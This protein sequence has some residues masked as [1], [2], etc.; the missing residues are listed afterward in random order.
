VN[1]DLDLLGIGVRLGI[2]FQLVSNILLL[3]AQP[4]AASSSITI[5]SI[6]MS[7]YF[8]SLL[9][10]FAN[11]NMP[12]GGI[13][14]S[15]GFLLMD[16]AAL[17]PTSLLAQTTLVEGLSF[18]TFLV[19]EIRQLF[20]LGFFVWF[21]YT[22]INAPQCR[23]PRVFMFANCGAYGGVG[24]F[25]RI[26]AT[27]GVISVA[28]TIW[29]TAKDV[30]N[31]LSREDQTRWTVTKQEIIDKAWGLKKIVAMTEHVPPEFRNA[32]F[33]VGSIVIMFFLILFIELE[34]KWNH[35]NNLGG[36]SSTGQIF[37]FIVGLFS[38][39]RALFDLAMLK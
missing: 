12:P 7:A 38:F 28:Y 18:W 17:N 31:R 26:L 34:I 20:A 14:C 3:R 36:I 6:F 10:S 16:I 37:P 29:K 11:S 39:I 25:F 19:A 22:G 30:V 1:V 35:F 13:I 24:I 33:M 23:E 27:V 32:G 5:S 9:Y 15:I 4:D 8:I 2:Y 21:W